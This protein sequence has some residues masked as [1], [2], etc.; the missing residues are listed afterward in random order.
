MVG[1]AQLADVQADGV[2]GHLAQGIDAVV[3]VSGVDVVV[4]EHEAS[5]V[6]GTR[7]IIPWRGGGTVGWARAVQGE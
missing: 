4:K 3:G 1:E 6:A 7:A 5:F 2:E